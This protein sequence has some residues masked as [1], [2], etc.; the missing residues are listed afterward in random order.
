MLTK[1]KNLNRFMG[2]H[3]DVRA[4]LLNYIDQ[5]KGMGESVHPIDA[6]RKLERMIRIEIGDHDRGSAE[7][8]FWMR[9]HK[10][11]GCYLKEV[12][13]TGTT[14]PVLVEA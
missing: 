2:K 5:K 4:A 14:N 8:T 11:L 12:A 13:M 3:E 10:I 7:H 9:Q 6:M 1:N